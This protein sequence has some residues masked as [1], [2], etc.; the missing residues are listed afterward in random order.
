MFRY[1]PVTADSWE[2]AKRRRTAVVGRERQTD[3]TCAE[4]AAGNGPH[5]AREK[6][7][8]ARI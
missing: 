3:A 8:H 4:L 2:I 1:R 5:L 7:A 6:F